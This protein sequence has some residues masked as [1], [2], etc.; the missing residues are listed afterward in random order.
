MSGQFVKPEDSQVPVHSLEKVRAAGLDPNLVP[1]CAVARKDEILGCRH[2]KRCAKEG[3]GR[4]ENLGFGPKSDAP[5]SSGTPSF[6][7]VYLADKAS[8]TETMTEMSCF[9]YMGAVHKRAKQQ[10]ITDDEVIILGGAG[11]EYLRR[12]LVPKDPN[13]NKTLDTTM[14]EVIERVKVREWP[15]IIAQS[16]MLE[17]AK[18]MKAIRQRALRRRLPGA[19]E[20]QELHEEVDED[21]GDVAGDAPLVSA[22]PRRG[23]RRAAGAGD[24]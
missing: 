22:K 23:G 20:P 17:H 14:T 7:A 13:N 2:A 6:I 5:G 10:G 11:T 15:E 1:C 21:E 16:P 3:F 12:R 18:E 9:S 24:S 8:S 19:D 4:E